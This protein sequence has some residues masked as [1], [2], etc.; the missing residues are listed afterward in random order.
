M[1]PEWKQNVKGVVL[2]LLYE[3]THVAHMETRCDRCGFGIAM[4]TIPCGP[5]GNKMSGDVVL[6]LLCGQPPVAQIE[7][8]ACQKGCLSNRGVGLRGVCLMLD[9]IFLK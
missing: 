8:A 6:V 4:S 3:Q 9:I 1:W 7:T 2:V 5:H